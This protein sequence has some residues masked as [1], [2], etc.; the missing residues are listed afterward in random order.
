MVT[1]GITFGKSGI[2]QLKRKADE[3]FRSRL[4]LYLPQLLVLAVITGFNVSVALLL[5]SWLE[6]PLIYYEYILIIPLCLWVRKWYLRA[7]MFGGVV[8]FDTLHL[9]AKCYE[10]N[11]IV[12]LSR[13]PELF[14][15]SFGWKFWLIAT[16][17]L[18]VLI[19]AV[20]G[21]VALL[22]W[23]DNKDAASRTPL[24]FL[25]ISGFLLFFLLG[26]VVNGTCWLFGQHAGRFRFCVA[27]TLAHIELQ[28]AREWGLG[29][30]PISRLH[31][32]AFYAHRDSPSFTFF[33]PNAKRQML[34]LVESWG[35]VRDEALRTSGKKIFLNL[36]LP[37]Y[38]VTFGSCPSYGSTYGAE[39]R[40]LLNMEPAG[41]Y[42][43]LNHGIEG[44]Q[45]LVSRMKQQGKDSIAVFPFLPQV[46][47]E[48]GV[49]R[50]LG[51]DEILSFNELRSLR[52]TAEKTNDESQYLAVDDEIAIEEAIR[53]VSG[54]PK[55]FAYVLTVNT[56]QPFK[57]SS[58]RKESPAYLAF[59]SHWRSHF[60]SAESMDQYYRVI[61]ELAALAKDL[62]VGRIDEIIVVGDHRPRFM[63]ES[64]QRLYSPA[65]VPY[66]VLRKKT[67]D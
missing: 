8:F 43:V 63:T 17:G 28:E 2:A 21:L 49:R 15:S 34:V 44:L 57:L 37:K 45:T 16:A 40:E 50:K 52:G 27:C 41:Y 53:K 20:W 3:V 67:S 22:R 61:T 11:D 56:H 58:A 26:D 6:R 9:I 36:L 12:F 42:S 31:S 65:L 7:L 29:R 5:P 46:T 10:Y 23:S 54:R 4:S 25:P 64:E 66:V 55:A 62:S 60:P 19:A 51:F 47:H 59:A 13:L 18:T 32:Y 35:L 1:G 39:A 30:K 38:S 24:W 14:Q 33:T 48:Y